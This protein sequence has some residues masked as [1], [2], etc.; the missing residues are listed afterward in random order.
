MF[1]GVQNLTFVAKLHFSSPSVYKEIYNLS[2]KWDKDHQLYCA[3][4]LDSFFGCPRYPEVKL[5]RAVL[6]PFFSKAAIVK[7]QYL[8]QE[9]VSRLTRVVPSLKVSDYSD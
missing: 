3:T 6:N 8:V 4:D 5:R 2:N 1:A 9:R 7:M